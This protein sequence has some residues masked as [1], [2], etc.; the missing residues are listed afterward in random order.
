MVVVVVDILVL[1]LRLVV[2]LVL[3]LVLRLV[4]VVVTVAGRRRWRRCSYRRGPRTSAQSTRS[5]QR[6]GQSWMATIASPPGQVCHYMSWPLGYK[7]NHARHELE[8]CLRC[9]TLPSILTTLTTV[10]NFTPSR[11]DYVIR[12]KEYERERRLRLRAKRIAAAAGAE[13]E[14]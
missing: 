9:V 8:H 5:R 13:E 1:V 2:V 6:W 14:E 7:C 3:V 4:V 11:E 10:T 12:M